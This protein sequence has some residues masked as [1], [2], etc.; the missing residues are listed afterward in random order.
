[1]PSLGDRLKHAWNAFNGQ[2]KYYNYN[3]IG[4]GSYYRPDHMRMTRG[5]EQSIL[6]SIITR[7]SIDVSSVG[8]KHVKLD[9]NGGFKEEVDDKLNYCLTTQANIDQTARDFLQSSVAMMLDVGHVAI[10]PVVTDANPL[11][12]DS[13]DIVSMRAGKVVAWY[14]KH[15]RVDLYNDETG[16]HEELILPKRMVSISYNPFYSVMNE[17]NSTFQRLKRKLVILDAIDEQSGSGKLDLI[18]QL[19]YSIKSEGRRKQAEDRRTDIERQLTGSKYGIAYIDST[20]HVTQLNRAVENNLMK[21]IE[22]LTGEVYGQ[23]GLTNEIINGT[24]DEQTML[25]YNNRTVEPILSAII[26]PM[27]CTFLTKTARTQG[28]SIIFFRDPF[29]LAPVSQLA[30]L[31]DKFLRNEIMSPNEFRVKALGFKAVDDPSAD[32]LRN[33]NLNQ[34]SQEMSDNSIQEAQMM[35]ENG[36]ISEE[37]YQELMRQFDEIDSEL[38]GLEQEYG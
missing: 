7:I 30:E 16:R 8:I 15:V 36:D 33:R 22:Y 13:Y 5:S 20:E 3:A 27:K 19:P 17:P 10:V 9:Q 6:N 25:N 18:I 14:P 4:S 32:Q 21:Q 12:T 38:D 26:D 35:L 28:H 1:M 24:A 34:N 2:D 23:I 37:E 29:K 11:R 31:S